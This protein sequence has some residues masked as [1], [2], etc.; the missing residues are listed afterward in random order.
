MRFSI[1]SLILSLFLLFVGCSDRKKEAGELE[2][3]LRNMDNAATDSMLADSAEM[4]DS[5]SDS[6][7]SD[8]MAVPE[9]ET[10]ELTMPQRPDGEGFTVQVASCEN[11]EYAQYLVDLF[12]K[13]G[14]EPY[15]TTYTDE[16]MTHYRVR[17]GVFSTHGEAKSL[18]DELADKYSLE[19]WVDVN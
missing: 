19:T 5:L 8:A 11:T 17:I 6:M 1:L 7:S 13:R 15:V 3:Q 14:Y 2:D 12:I 18:A 16:E 10:P 4:V 9:E